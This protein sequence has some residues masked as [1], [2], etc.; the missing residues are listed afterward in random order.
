MS[1]PK[2]STAFK[3]DLDWSQLKET[4]LMLNLSIAQIDQS[5]SEGS[6]SIDTL[7]LS[8]TALA[9]QLNHIQSI[10]THIDNEPSSNNENLKSDINTSAQSALDQVQ[11]AIVAFQFYDKLS[12]RMEHISSSLTSLNQLIADPNSLYSPPQWNVL[13]EKIRATYTMDEEREMFDKVLSGISIEQAIQE[14]NLE[15]ER[16]KETQDDIE[17]F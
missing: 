3:P 10:S 11:S 5:M 1:N 2:G 9:S 15:I 17:L 6:N 12:Q 8:F 13:Q 16:K 14:F 4:I 7:A